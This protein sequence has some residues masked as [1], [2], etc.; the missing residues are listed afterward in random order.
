MS[1]ELSL[2]SGLRRSTRGPSPR[3]GGGSGSPAT[4]S[5]LRGCHE[6]GRESLWFS[7][8]ISP[9]R[10]GALGGREIVSLVELGQSLPLSITPQARVKGMAI[11]GGVG[12]DHFRT[13]AFRAG[14][15]QRQIW[16]WLG[17]AERV[18]HIGRKVSC[19]PQA[20]HD[21]RPEPPARGGASAGAPPTPLQ[22]QRPAPGPRASLPP[23]AGGSAAARAG[24]A[25]P[26]HC[27][28]ATRGSAAGRE[29]GPGA[30]R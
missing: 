12:R 3:P 11:P 6:A 10:A 1:L 30:G 23:S 9:H 4:G 16:D 13:R 15:S 25:P 26:Q 24:E 8:G 2:L 22:R 5:P 29:A 21:L 18:F 27:R 14:A 17:G 7:W 28:T 19:P 20:R